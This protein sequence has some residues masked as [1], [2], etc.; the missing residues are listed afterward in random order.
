M[1]LP[2]HARM[3]AFSA[4]LANRVIDFIRMSHA[5]GDMLGGEVRSLFSARGTAAGGLYHGRNFLC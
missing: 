1:R 2:N 3:I 4:N 5:C